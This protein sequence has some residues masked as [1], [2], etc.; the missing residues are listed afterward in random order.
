MII[1]TKALFKNEEEESNKCFKTNYL[2][3]ESFSSFI[4]NEGHMDLQDL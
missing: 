3:I 2:E 1:E 4:L